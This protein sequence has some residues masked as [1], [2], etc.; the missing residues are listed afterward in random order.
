MQR[1]Q[2]EESRREQEERKKQQQQQE[3]NQLHTLQQQTQPT[4]VMSGHQQQGPLL[5][6]EDFEQQQEVNVAADHADFFTLFAP[7]V[8][9]QQLPAQRRIQQNP[10]IIRADS[11]QPIR[12]QYN[13]VSQAPLQEEEGVPEQYKQYI[14]ENLLSLWIFP[15]QF[16]KG[17]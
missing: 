1:E 13:R 10:I 14:P 3:Q 11:A 7:Q 6:Q 16:F 8:Q 9:S 4:L 5:Q 15:I 17:L 2:E 12:T